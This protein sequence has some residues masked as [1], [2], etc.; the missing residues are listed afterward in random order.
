[1]RLATERNRKLFRRRLVRHRDKM[2][3]LVRRH[4]EARA[5][6][7]V[8]RRRVLAQAPSFWV[9]TRR[10][11]RLG[12]IVLATLLAF[13]MW[14]CCW[15]L[16]PFAPKAM[17]P[18][19]RAILKLW[20]RSLLRI[21][22][23][24]LEVWGRPPKPPCYIVANHLGYVDIWALA[25]VTGA[26]FVAKADM[27]SWPL[28]GWFMKQSHQIFIRRESLKDSQRVMGLL[29][30]V[31]DKDD[32][33]VVFAEGRCS[34]GVE[35]LPFRPSL[36]QIAAEREFPVHYAA[37]S[38]S[39]PEGEPAAADSISWWRWEP[40]GEQMARLLR[41]SRSTARVYF[42]PQPVVSKCRKELARKTH[43]GVS[44]LFVPIAQGV[45]EELPCP[46][47]APVWLFPEKKNAV[48]ITPSEEKPKAFF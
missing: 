1:M 32:C 14:M 22:N 47:D 28:M 36:F 30:E 11:L 7:H 38:F 20:G 13:G 17:R 48:N 9:E 35:V 12:L 31:L 43:A 45:L 23:M 34:R 5:M 24:K 41:L 40:L 42:G 4:R 27:E 33:L 37:L 46:E 2:R 26:V 18:L 6:R 29:Q 16:Q 25:A 15:P 3:A 39:T 8:E 10:R 21:I 19:R 44:E